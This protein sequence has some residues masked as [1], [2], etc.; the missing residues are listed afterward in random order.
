M[1]ASRFPVD[2]VRSTEQDFD[3]IAAVFGN[4]TPSLAQKFAQTCTAL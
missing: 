4:S 1:I 3:N 2:W